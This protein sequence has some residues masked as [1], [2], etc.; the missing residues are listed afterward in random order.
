VRRVFVDSG[1]FFALLAAEDSFHDHA[2]S[3]FSRANQ[4][5]WHLATTNA[6]VVE[7][8]SLL[9]VRSRGG[10]RSALAFLD[11]V[12]DDAYHV[13]RVGKR[14]EERAIALLR[15]H[16]DKSYSL[17]DA[18]SFVVMERLRIR[19]VVAFDRHFRAYGRFTI[20]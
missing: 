17:C 2:R 1:G 3:L 14:D 7:T 6:V 15:A 4:E 12:G 16:K 20:L 18:L 11:M 19:D 5:R 9:L 8:Y 13:E 10:R